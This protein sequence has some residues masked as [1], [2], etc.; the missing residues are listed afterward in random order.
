VKIALVSPSATFEKEL[1]ETALAQARALDIAIINSTSVRTTNPRFLNGSKA[2]RLQELRAAELLGADA[3]WCTRGGCGALELWHDYGPE[4]YSDTRSPLVG[5]SDITVLHF[6]RFY[7]AARIGIH[8]PVFLESDLNLDAV[9]LLLYKRAQQITY[10]PLKAR[11]YF[12]PKIISG[13]LLV[14]NLISLQSIIGLFAPNFMRGKILAIEEINEPHYKIYRALL[15]LKNAGALVG[16]KGLI[17]GHI[18]HER[19][20]IIKHTLIPLV[21]DLGIPLFDWPIFGHE[22]PH[23]PLL[24][25]ARVSISQVDNEIFVIAYN[26]QHDHEPIDVAINTKYY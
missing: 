16:L 24:F 7:H 5:Y 18:S 12:L 10:P 21:K 11:N 25:G 13:E 20:E 6:L 22:K 15:Q 26:E 14:M 3:L 17:I 9:K 4:I 8:G 2:E 1:L 19:E 23:W